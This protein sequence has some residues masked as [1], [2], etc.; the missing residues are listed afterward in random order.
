MEMN[1]KEIIA[2]RRFGKS[3][4]TFRK[5]I[6]YALKGEKCC[7]KSQDRE[8][9]YVLS[10]STLKSIIKAE[11]ESLLSELGEGH[12]M[13]WVNVKSLMPK[14]DKYGFSSRYVCYGHGEIYLSFLANGKWVLDGISDR[15]MKVECWC[16]ISLP[17]ED[18]IK[19]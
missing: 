6:E 15:E 1:K 13:Y 3:L 5:L 8:N 9:V 12:K 17:L 11:R 14:M 7:Y 2:P 4:D 19:E 10:N 18:K 16:Y